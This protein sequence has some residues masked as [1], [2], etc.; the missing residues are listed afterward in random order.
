MKRT[1]LVASEFLLALLLLSIPAVSSSKDANPTAG[2]PAPQISSVHT[3][4]GVMPAGNDTGGG[5]VGSESQPAPSAN[6]PLAT[7]FAGLSY[8]MTYACGSGFPCTNRATPPDVQI[9]AG[10]NY[11]VE[12]VNIFYG[13]WTKQGALVKVSGL[14]S[15]WGSGSDYIGDP[16]VLYDPQSGRR[17]ASMLDVSQRS[18]RVRPSASDEP[19]GS[20]H[21]YAC[22]PS[23]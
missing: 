7:G 18:L 6:S 10:P 15:L 3:I 17:F 21:S 9:A 1:R 14:A 20:C 23:A 4:Q 2:R 19:S 12:M 13:V 16:K 22:A 5:V 8:G 11:I